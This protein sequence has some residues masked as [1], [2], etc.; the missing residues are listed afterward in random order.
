[1]LCYVTNVC[2]SPN[3]GVQPTDDYSYLL[4]FADN[5]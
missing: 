2:I 3:F 1:M 5:C 4:S